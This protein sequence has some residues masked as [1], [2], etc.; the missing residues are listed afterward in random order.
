MFDTQTFAVECVNTVIPMVPENSSFGV[1]FI[2][3]DMK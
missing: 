2:L 1:S 3:S